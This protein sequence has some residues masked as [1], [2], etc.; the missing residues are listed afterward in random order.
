MVKL[1][2]PC[3]SFLGKKMG[4]HESVH[5]LVFGHPL[6]SYCKSRQ[7][8]I[9]KYGKIYNAICNDII[10]PGNIKF[11]LVADFSEKL[12]ISVLCYTP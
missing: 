10:L 7:I 2:H 12:Q 9:V 3:V 6:I 8:S 1:L 5:M 11:D 4:A